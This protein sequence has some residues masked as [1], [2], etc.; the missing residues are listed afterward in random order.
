[1]SDMILLYTDITNITHNIIITYNTNTTNVIEA[2]LGD[3]V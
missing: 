1:M 3:L 2:L